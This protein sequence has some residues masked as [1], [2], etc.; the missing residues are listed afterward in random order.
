MSLPFVSYQRVRFEHCYGDEDLMGHL[1]KI[2]SATHVRTMSAV[3][4]GR[5][6]A[7]LLLTDALD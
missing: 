4:L 7:L 3:T 2:A 6:R 1:R 5:Y